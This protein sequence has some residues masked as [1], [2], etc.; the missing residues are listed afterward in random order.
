[1]T[2]TSSTPP[3]P[4]RI[5]FFAGVWY[6]LLKIKKRYGW[7]AFFLAYGACSCQSTFTGW[8]DVEQQWHTLLE[9]L[10]AKRETS[11]TE[12]LADLPDLG[13]EE[14]R[15]RLQSIIDGHKK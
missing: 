8:A 3:N 11:T 2:T 4:Y 7:R 12:T 10:K 6:Y 1:M 5:L 14:L 9:T 13:N 15:Q